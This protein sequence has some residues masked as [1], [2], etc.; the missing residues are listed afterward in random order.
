MGLLFPPGKCLSNT[1]TGPIPLP[2][3]RLRIHHLFIRQPLTLHNLTWSNTNYFRSG[4]EMLWIWFAASYYWILWALQCLVTSRH[5]QRYPQSQGINN[6]TSLLH[7]RTVVVSDGRLT[8][9]MA[10]KQFVRFQRSS[11]WVMNLTWPIK[12]PVCKNI[13]FGILQHRARPSA[14]CRKRKSQ[15]SNINK[16]CSPQ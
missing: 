15:A 12:A 10:G 3:R 13:Y 5:C 2:S 14:P 4:G 1:S 16:H 8:V 9:Y 6:S 7:I 11:V